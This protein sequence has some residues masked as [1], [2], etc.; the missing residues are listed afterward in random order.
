MEKEKFERVVAIHK[1]LKGLY[2]A[3]REISPKTSHSLSYIDK[4][5]K[6]CSEWTIREIGEILDKYDEM[7]RAELQ[8]EIDSLHAEIEAL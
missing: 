2:D 4:N 3:L 1:R 6:G 7:I 5:N 8:Q